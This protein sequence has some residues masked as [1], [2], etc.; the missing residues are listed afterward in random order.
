[1]RPLSLCHL[2][3]VP[4]CPKCGVHLL[5]KALLLHS[6]RRLQPTLRLH[7]LLVPLIMDLYSTLCNFLSAGTT[8]TVPSSSISVHFSWEREPA[9]DGWTQFPVD[10]PAVED[11]T[12]TLESLQFLV[13]HHF[14][15]ATFYS[16]EEPRQL[17]VRIYLIPWDL[18]GFKGELQ[19]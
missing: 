13:R 14:I 9:E 18:P 2:L 7:P 3:A 10:V 8:L 19:R 1:M 17:F 15:I 12:G 16:Q 4:S 5:L 11:T 6:D